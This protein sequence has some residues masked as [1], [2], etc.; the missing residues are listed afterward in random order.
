MAKRNVKSPQTNQSP[1]NPVAEI[2]IAGTIVLACI[3]AVLVALTIRLFRWITG[4]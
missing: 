2:R 4:F 1:A 3:V